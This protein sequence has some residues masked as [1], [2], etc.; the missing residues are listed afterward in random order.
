MGSYRQVVIFMKDLRIKIFPL[1][2]N[3]NINQRQHFIKRRLDFQKIYK[4]CN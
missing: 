3:F 1:I 4:K 2:L